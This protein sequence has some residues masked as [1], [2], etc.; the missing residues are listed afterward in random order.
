MGACRVFNLRAGLFCLDQ[1]QGKILVSGNF[2]TIDRK[3]ESK[4][5]KENDNYRASSP[6]QD[7]IAI[8]K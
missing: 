4:M 1:I 7:Q 2:R 5:T 6:I 8:H 3:A